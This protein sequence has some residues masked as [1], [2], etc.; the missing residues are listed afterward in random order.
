[1]RDVDADRRADPLLLPGMC[2]ATDLTQDP[3]RQL[4]AGQALLGGVD[5]RVGPQQPML[6]MLPA[7]QRLD[8]DDPPHA[9]DCPHRLVVQLQ[10]ALGHRPPQLR[11]QAGPPREDRVRAFMKGDPP[12]AGRLGLVHRGVGMAQQ[13]LGVVGIGRVQA[14]ADAGSGAQLAPD[15]V[16]RLAQGI[17]ELAADV[18][19]PD[20]G[21]GGQ[22]GEQHEE[23]VSTQPGE[24]VGV[25]QDRVQAC[26]HA[27]QQLVSRGVAQPVVDL[28]E[29]VQID[30]HQ[31][32]RPI[33]A[34]RPRE[35]ELHLLLG[36]DAVGQLG[37]RVVIGHV[38]QLFLP[39]PALGDVAHE[40]IEHE[41]VVLG[42][43][44]QRERQLDGELAAVGAHRHELG[45]APEQPPLPGRQPVGEGTAMLL[46]AGRRD[47]QLGQLAADG[48]GGPIAERALG[49]RVELQHPAGAVD[50]DHAVQRRGEHRAVALHRALEGVQLARALDRDRGVGGEHAQHL[51]L[52]LV[53]TTAADRVIDRDDAIAPAARPLDRREQGVVR[54]PVALGRRG[55][56][57]HLR[58]VP[59][60][61]RVEL[62]EGHRPRRDEEHVPAREPG[63]EQRLPGRAGG[64]VAEQDAAGPLGAVDGDHLVGV[65]R[66]PIDV[67]DDGRER[68]RLGDR[69]RHRVEHLGQR[70]LA[71][72]ETGQ[73]QQ[74]PQRG[75]RHTGTVGALWHGGMV[76]VVHLL[77]AMQGQGPI[78]P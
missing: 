62:L 21:V 63:I 70:R 15:Q 2:L 19:D 41:I 51:Q 20:G 66:G 46:A 64:D 34:P 4:V 35:R 42:A 38:G 50:R 6:G 55:V 59:L 74:A 22:V 16:E 53:G 61:R 18:L 77:V 25:T 57:G 23:L 13:R 33:A 28:L 67:D 73:R 37:Q 71:Q 65:I 39:A 8:A 72:A 5:E 24:Q 26:G 52:T 75:D 48:V 76:V 58:R 47:D 45:P 32:D 17:E 69:S 68:D 56:I 27:G 40:P 7:Q 49:G 43:L 31:R 10:F 29:T 78:R 9:L 30:E 54:P 12:P 3:R 11:R 44:G 60:G 1:M 14:D 36:E